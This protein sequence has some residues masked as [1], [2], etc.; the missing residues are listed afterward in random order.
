M[1]VCDWK[2]MALALFWSLSFGCADAVVA[3]A[4]DAAV[5]DAAATA[6]ANRIRCPDDVDAVVSDESER[7][8]LTALV[9]CCGDRLGVWGDLELSRR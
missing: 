8:R 3:V 4:L 7:D 2:L 6:L 1:L 9:A 5:A